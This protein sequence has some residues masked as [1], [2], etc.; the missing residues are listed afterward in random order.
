MIDSA[1]DIINKE[2]DK[3]TNWIEAY[4]KDDDT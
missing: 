4:F 1:T 2:S 3:S